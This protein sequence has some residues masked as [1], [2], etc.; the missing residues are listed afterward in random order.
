MAFNKVFSPETYTEVQKSL[1]CAWSP[2]RLYGCKEGKSLGFLQNFPSIYIYLKMLFKEVLLFPI[3]EYEN[4]GMPELMT[5]PDSLGLLDLMARDTRDS[6]FTQALL[7]QNQIGKGRCQ[8]YRTMN[9][10]VL[11]G[12]MNTLKFIQFCRR[13]WANSYQKNLSGLL[14]MRCQLHLWI[15]AVDSCR[16]PDLGLRVASGLPQYDWFLFVHPPCC[17]KPFCAGYEYWAELRDNSYSG[18]GKMIVHSAAAAS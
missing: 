1:W 4:W 11:L 3:W 15:R 6:S 16:R 17:K 12:I 5:P 7:V 18:L 13:N 8:T 10:V 9:S 14:H 2:W